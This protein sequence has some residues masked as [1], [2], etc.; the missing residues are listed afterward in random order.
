M[1]PFYGDKN[2]ALIHFTG[3]QL[4]II[5]FPIQSGL[6]QTGFELYIIFPGGSLIQF[7]DKF[8]VF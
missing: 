7:E 3:I 8:L 6:E 4:K 2:R 1:C 5:Y